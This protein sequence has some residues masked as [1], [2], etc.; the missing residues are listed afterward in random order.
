M[1]ETEEEA[2][3]ECDHLTN[4]AILLVCY[5]MPYHKQGN[6]T[7]SLPHPPPGCGTKKGGNRQHTS[8]PQKDSGGIL[9]C[10]SRRVH[11][12]PPP[13]NPH[14]HPLKVRS[15]LYGVAS[16]FYEASP[17]ATHMHVQTLFLHVKILPYSGLF[18]WGCQFSLFS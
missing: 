11:S 5:K 17:P 2:M 13:H 3:C 18:S 12:L 15:S 4:F 9:L 14:I 7:L 16:L 6:T 10:W 1:N 8:S